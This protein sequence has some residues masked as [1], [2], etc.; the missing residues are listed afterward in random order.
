MLL[1]VRANPNVHEDTLS[2]N[3]S[4]ARCKNDREVLYDESTALTFWQHMH[5]HRS[6]MDSVHVFTRYVPQYPDSGHDITAS[7]LI[8][9]DGAS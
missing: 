6:L 9:E 7:L 5:L 1:L 4:A 3:V 8:P 2:V